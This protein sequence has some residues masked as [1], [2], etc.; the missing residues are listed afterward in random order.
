MESVA[1]TE[2]GGILLILA[3]AYYVFTHPEQFDKYF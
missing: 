2:W 1:Q 3:S